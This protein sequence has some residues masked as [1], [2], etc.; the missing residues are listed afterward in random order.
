[1]KKTLLITGFDPFGGAD[2]NPAWEA[3]KALP[4]TV[5]NYELRKLQIP[6][7][8]GEAAG[9]VL[10]A[11]R[12]IGPDVIL[13]VGQAGGRSAVTP[14][15]I[16]VN[17]RDARIPDNRGNQPEGEF[18]AA[19]GPAAY[20]ST[21]PVKEMAAAIAA[22][23]LPGTVSNSAGAFVC[24]DT[25]YVLLHNYRGTATRVGFVHVPWLPEQGNPSLP[26]ED[27]VRALEAAI[28]AL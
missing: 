14:E 1:V 16:A 4:D 19:E 28:G 17:I 27:T 5:G 8:F 22:A 25:L 13:C 24:N 21:V 10:D 23:G 18:V 15:R 9:N 3:V 12:K 7:V 20:F 11:A 2:I 26:L 6:T